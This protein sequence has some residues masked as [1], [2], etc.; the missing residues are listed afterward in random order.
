MSFAIMTTLN[1]SEY[2]TR[3]DKPTQHSYQVLLCC[4]I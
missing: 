3:Q 1:L 4:I 2:I